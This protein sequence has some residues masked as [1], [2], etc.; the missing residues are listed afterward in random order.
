MTTEGNG[1]GAAGQDAGGNDD[2]GGKPETMLDKA[3]AAA[4]DADAKGSPADKVAAPADGGFDMAQLPEHLRGESPD[5]ALGKVFKAYQGLRDSGVKPP[6]KSD[7]YSF[8]IGAE[9]KPYFPDLDNDP[10]L[11]AFR[12]T[13]HE[14]GLGQEQFQKI[15]NGVTEAMAKDGVLEKPI[16]ANAEA[17]KL[18]GEQQAFARINTV[19]K[20]L[21]LQKTNQ[22]LTEGEHLQLSLMMAEADGVTALEKIM[23]NSGQQGPGTGGDQGH[24][25]GYTMDDYRRDMKDERYDTHSPKYDPDF[26]ARV[27][28]L[29]K[30]ASSRK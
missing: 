27:D 2:A 21:D 30:Q 18:G 20:W 25:Q 28:R 22:V 26:R 16:D 6:E 4:A 5:D 24:D 13:A 7:D 10:M 17:A 11:K 19:D 8:D 12:K 15:V 29:G 1:E 9:A 23:K 14:A 3:R